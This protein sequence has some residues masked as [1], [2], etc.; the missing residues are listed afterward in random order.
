[1]DTGHGSDLQTIQCG[2]LGKL[3]PSGKA[4]KAG[5]QQVITYTV[6]I[7]NDLHYSKCIDFNL[8]N[9][10]RFIYIDR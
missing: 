9:R 10:F 6:Q 4:A 1:M 7:V 3:Q 8:F 5:Q 2:S